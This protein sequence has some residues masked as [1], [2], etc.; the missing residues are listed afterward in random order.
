VRIEEKPQVSQPAPFSSGQ[1]TVI[2]NSTL[3]AE[4][5]GSHILLTK[6]GASLAKVVDALNLLGVGPSDLVEILQALKQAGA[7]KAE[8]EV[9]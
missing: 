9:L 2:P 1:T 3:D 5:T 6:G 4:E 8:M 7:L